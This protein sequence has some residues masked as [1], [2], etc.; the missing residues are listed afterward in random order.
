MLNQSSLNWI[1][2]NIP[3]F[4]PVVFAVTNRPVVKTDLPNL[5]FISKL[6]MKFVGTAAFD[7]LYSLLQRGRLSGSQKQMKMIRHDYEFVQ[8]IYALF[9]TPKNT[10]NQNF[11]S[12]RHSEKLAPLPSSGRDEIGAPEGSPVR[13]FTHLSFRG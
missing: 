2:V 9:A 12:L 5:H 4:R 3:D 1:H 11:C 8:P 10:L 7:K 6:R 13:E